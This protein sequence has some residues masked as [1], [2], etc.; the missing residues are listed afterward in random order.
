[1]Y[2]SFQLAIKFLQHYLAASNSRGHGM[3][4][5][6]VYDFIRNVLNNDHH[7]FPPPGIEALRHRLLEDDRIIGIND[8]GAG[9]R[10]TKSNRRTVSHLA[11][12][13]LKPVKYARL[14]YRLAVHYQPGSIIE[15]G[16]S[17]GLTTAYFSKARPASD[18]ITIEGSSAIADI[19]RE[20]L[21]LLGCSN[22]QVMTGN[23]DDLLPSILSRQKSLDLVYI[24]GNH[25]YAPTMDYF[26]QCVDRS[27]NDTI[28]IFDDIHWSPDME[29]AWKDI[30]SDSRVQYTIDIF[31]LG[32]VFF[33][34]DFRVKQDFR[35]RF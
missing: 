10:R 30:C 22:V 21:Q 34:K 17:L 4:S 35:I 19:A 14:L 20:N 3:H 12:N 27:G 1:V 7:Y 18:L 32:F 11:A 23:F 28:L 16:T 26:R 5:P 8:L 9:S 25:R 29:R 15:L 33:R 13:S 2:N 31:F 24:D 6:F